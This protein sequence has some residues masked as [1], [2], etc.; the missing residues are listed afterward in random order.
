LLVTN[1]LPPAASSPIINGANFQFTFNGIP[2]LTNTVQTNGN[3]SGGTW[4]VWTNIPPPANNNPI[5]VINPPGQPNL[6]FR[7]LVLP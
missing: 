3:L 4:G 5:T 1:P 6:F 7:V 2:G